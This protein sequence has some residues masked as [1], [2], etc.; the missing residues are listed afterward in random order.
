LIFS[1]RYRALLILSLLHFLTK[2]YLYHLQEDAIHWAWTLLTKVYGLPADRLYATYFEGNETLGLP[3]DNE[4]RDL[5]LK[6]LP[7]ERV[8][9]GTFTACVHTTAIDT[10]LV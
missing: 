2:P 3:P 8:L 7:A 6:Y 9:T 4:A 1:I 5:W 10:T